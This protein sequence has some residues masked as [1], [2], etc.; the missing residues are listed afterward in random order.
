MRKDKRRGVSLGSVLMIALTVLVIALCALFLLAIV[1]DDVYERTGA[2]MHL[3]TEQGLLG[4]DERTPEPTLT[5]DGATPEPVAVPVMA[6]IAEASPIPAPQISAFTLAAS[7][8]VYA[9][10]A[11]RTSAQ[12]AAGNYDFTEIFAGLGDAFSAADLSI[13]TLETT[14]AGEEKG[15][16]SYNTPPQILDALRAQGVDF[17]S[18]A[19]ERALDKGYNGLEITLRELNSRAL[20]YV[21]VGD[22]GAQMLNIGGVQVAILAY[23]YGLSDEGSEQTKGDE[24]GM[25]ALIDAERMTRDIVSAR[26]N[27]A[28]VVI[29]LP[30]WGTKNR[31]ETPDSVRTLAR[32]LA[33]AGA[34]V[35]LGTH[36]N[37]VQGTERLRV[38]RSDGLEYDAVVCYSLGSLLTDARAPENTAGVVAYLTISYDPAE[39]RASLGELA[40]TPLYIASQREEGETVYRVVDVENVAAM[41]ALQEDEREAAKQAAQ[42][43]R[44]I[45]GQSAREEEGQ[46]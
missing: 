15:Y 13:V 46:G 41:A 1:G 42:A 8:T 43:V 34:D 12:D 5:P 24:R 7:G 3:L 30:H 6:A 32:T 45:T 11:V 28:N 40:C 36:P 25:L 39:R 9:P 2:L 38:T 35:I 44:E 4:L 22:G 27:G 37:V 19:T 18:L 33:E 17:V 16:G 20:S 26:L 21:G 29:V 23:A 14:T 31:Q 10:K